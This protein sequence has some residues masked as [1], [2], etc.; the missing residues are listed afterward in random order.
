VTASLS[1]VSSAV[2]DVLDQAAADRGTVPL[3]VLAER[4]AAALGVRHGDVAIDLESGTHE[5]LTFSV[6]VSLWNGDYLADMTQLTVR[7]AV[8][9]PA[10]M[11]S[12]V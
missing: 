8:G 9:A 4:V 2:V 11:T 3:A 12:R 7:H 6:H 5:P 10:R 1:D